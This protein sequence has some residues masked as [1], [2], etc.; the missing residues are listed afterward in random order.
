MSNY[1]LYDKTQNIKHILF[2][3]LPGIGGNDYPYLMVLILF[4][5]RNFL[6]EYRIKIL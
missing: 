2:C 6:S 1:L 4:Y 3:Y 5:F